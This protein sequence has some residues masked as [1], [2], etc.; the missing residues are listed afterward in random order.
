MGCVS[1]KKEDFENLKYDPFLSEHILLEPDCDPDENF[2]NDSSIRNLDT[3]Y[4]LPN[5]VANSLKDLND[6][7]SVF[8]LNIRSMSKNFD[9]FKILLDQLN[10]TFKVII[11]TETWALDNQVSSNSIFRIPNYASIH[12]V[13]E[14]RNVGGV[15]IFVHE[16]LKF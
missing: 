12:Q 5:D 9:A 16:S 4:Y 7:F 15:S 13:R 10:F 1:N 11:L 3:P 2:F 6:S 8:H 14:K